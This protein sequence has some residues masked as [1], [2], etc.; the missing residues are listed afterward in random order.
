MNIIGIKGG[1]YSNVSIDAKDCV[2]SSDEPSKATVSNG[3][4]KGVAEGTTYIN[5]TYKDVKDVV[6]VTVTPAT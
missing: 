6:K 5:V 1:L 4:V 3:V 2:I